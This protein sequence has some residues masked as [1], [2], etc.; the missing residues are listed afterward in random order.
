MN[1]REEEWSEFMRAANRGCKRSYSR[2]LTSLASSLPRIIA[3]NLARLGLPKSDVED[4]VQEVLLAIHAKR[5]T[6]DE[7]RPLMPWLRAIVRHKVLDVARQRY[8]QS[9][10]VVASALG[11]VEVMEPEEEPR[12]VQIV[13]RHVDE[14][15]QQ[16]RKV[17]KALVFDGATIQETAE[18]LNISRNA[19]YVTLHR[20]VKGLMTRVGRDSQ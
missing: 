19:V 1:E 3:P 14:L 20:A 6:W 5:H 17:V 4:V 18:K 15:P 11:A 2:L 9:E 8:R 13:Q 7:T 12:S 10:A 16:Q